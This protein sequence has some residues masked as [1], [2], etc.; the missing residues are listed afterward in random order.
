MSAAIQVPSDAP[1][2]ARGVRQ[3]PRRGADFAALLTIVGLAVAACATSL[4]SGQVPSGPVVRPT[5][6]LPPRGPRTEAPRETC[7]PSGSMPAG[8]ASVG[9][10]GRIAY[11]SDDVRVTSIDGTNDQA[12]VTTE[13]DEF[14]PSWS[15]D[16]RKLAFRLAPGPGLGNAADI[17]VVDVATCQ[18]TNLTNLS[19]AY[20]WSPAW[21]P[22]GTTIAFASHRGTD[23]D[24][25]LYLMDTDGENVR[26]LTTGRSEGEYPAWSPDG[27]QIAFACYQGGGTAPGEVPDYDI[28]LID[29]GTGAIVNLTKS[30]SYEMYPA[31]SPR[32]DQIAFH[33][34]RDAP[35]PSGAPAG[36]DRDS[37]IFVMR[38][39]GSELTNLTRD[40]ATRDLYPTWSPDGSAIAFTTYPESFIEIIE[41]DGTGRRALPPTIRGDFPAWAP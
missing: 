12:V 34:D 36:E 19:S 3:H 37:D 16:G 35:R 30:P 18:V 38:P 33:S 2:G 21:S 10:T 32:G 29:V 9:I 27:R 5:Q 24:Q 41:S 7:R 28:C 17:A 31:W 22:D 20:N 15:P 40:A 8:S 1:S 14:D 26:S 25:N 4:P 11:S 6:T 23:R 39:D 13:A